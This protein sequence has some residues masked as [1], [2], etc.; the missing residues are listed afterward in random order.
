MAGAITSVRKF[1]ISD[2]VL[3]V[4]AA[5][6][7][8]GPRLVLNGQL[9]RKLY[10]AVNDVLVACGGKWD[11]KAKAHLFDGDAAD[12][13]EEAMLTGT[14][15]KVK[16]DFG[17]FFTPLPIAHIVAL[18]AKI[19]P[20]HR[21]LEPSAGDGGLLRVVFC[22][23]YL[24]VT[25]VEIQQQNCEKLAAI[26]P[27]APMAEIHCADFMAMDLT[28]L[29]VFDRIVMNPPFAKRADVHHIF[30]AWSLLKPGG[31]LVAIASA[32]VSF[33]T[34]ALTIELRQLVEARGTMEALPDGAFQESGTMVRT[35]LI[36]M[37]KPA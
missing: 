11:K 37:D 1:T 36:V 22:G 30:R 8:T 34:D 2:D 31:R 27:P 12:L 15:S 20:G 13:V 7:C 6:T 18:R 4:L 32:G 14:Y 29:G 16:Q 17:A 21:V 25:A 10:T 19:Q 9:E 24:T 35:V 5:A 26:C 28:P 33:R 23:T 3:N